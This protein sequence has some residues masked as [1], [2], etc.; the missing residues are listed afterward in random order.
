[1]LTYIAHIDLTS[2]TLPHLTHTDP[3]INL[4]KLTLFFQNFVLQ[5]KVINLTL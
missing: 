1:M 4:T 2:H 3:L 5:L